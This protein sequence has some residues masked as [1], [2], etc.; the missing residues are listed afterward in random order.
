MSTRSRATGHLSD[1]GDSALQGAQND[2]VDLQAL[3]SYGK[4]PSHNSVPREQQARQHMFRKPLYRD[5]NLV[6]MS[7]SWLR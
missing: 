7:S 4:N 2:V 1:N 6:L 3:Y 5:K